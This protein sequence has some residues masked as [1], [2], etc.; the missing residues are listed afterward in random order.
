MAWLNSQFTIEDAIT[1]DFDTWE[2]LITDWGYKGSAAIAADPYSWSF[3]KVGQ[4]GLPTVQ[5][6]AI[7]P[8]STVDR[9][10]VSYGLQKV[11]PGGINYDYSRRLV[12]GAPLMFAQVGTR[13][14][15][16]ASS[17]VVVPP[18]PP[19]PASGA[20]SLVVYPQSGLADTGGNQDTT[21]YGLNYY[22]TGP[23]A[24]PAGVGFFGPSALADGVNFQSPTLHLIFFLK[25]QAVAANTK[26]EPYVLNGQKTIPIASYNTYVLVAQVPTYGRKTVKVQVR[27]LDPSAEA[28]ATSTIRIGALQT[29]LTSGPQAAMTETLL[30]D[31]AAVVTDNLSAQVSLTD[32]RADYINLY[33]KVA[34]GALL[35]VAP[36]YQICAYDD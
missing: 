28:G 8:R 23:S 9:C 6:I 25:P 27:Y 15:V 7:G 3:P 34:G 31:T 22:R 32:V 2:L 11:I 36:R 30:A 26:R 14:I 24:P 17:P 21:M 1:R 4:R 19:T 13:E 29:M 18:T 10:F 20:A 12:L 35:S 16:Q 33:L 5:G